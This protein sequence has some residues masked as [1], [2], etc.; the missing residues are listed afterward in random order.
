MKPLPIPIPLD[1]ADEL[2][3]LPS[4]IC[5]M[6]AGRRPVPFLTAIKLME[7]ARTDKRLTGLCLTHLRPEQK[8]AIPYLCGNGKKGAGRGRR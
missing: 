2:Q 5:H 3:T 8:L 1:L 7:I 6:N 4:N